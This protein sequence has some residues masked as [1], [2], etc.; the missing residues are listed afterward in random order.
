MQALAESTGNIT[1]ETFMRLLRNHNDGTENAFRPDKGFTGSSVCMHAG[2][3]PIRGSQTVGSMVSHLDGEVPIHFVTGTAAPCTSIFKPVWID[4]PADMGPPPGAIYNEETLYWRHE[5]LH[6][7]MLQDM[8]LL[9]KFQ[10]ERNA[11]EDKFISRALL[12]SKKDG[13]SRRDFSNQAFADA[14]KLEKAWLSRLS[15]TPNK[16]QSLWHKSAWKKW[17]RLAG[18]PLLGENNER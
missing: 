14:D 9:E 1:V 11:L 12:I 13:N 10:S 3:G 15:E 8:S 5:L 2:P 18:I 17:N 4:A 16:N 6:R 7:T